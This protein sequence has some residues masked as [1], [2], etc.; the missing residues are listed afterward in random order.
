MRSRIYLLILVLWMTLTGNFASAQIFEWAKAFGHGTFVEVNDLAMD[1]LGDFYIVGSFKGTVDF[2]PGPG[3]LNL[4]SAGFE[5]A[6][7]TKYSSTGAFQWVKTWGSVY[8]DVAHAVEF[9]NGQLYIGGRFQD[10]V[11]FDPGPGSVMR[12]STGSGQSG[13]MLRLDPNGG[14]VDISC[15]YSAYACIVYDMTQDSVGN[16]YMCGTYSD[17][18]NFLGTN[19]T[20]DVLVDVFVAKAD[21]AMNLQW[22]RTFGRFIGQES[23]KSIEL[24]AA[25]SVYVSGSFSG[26][27]DMNPGPGVDNHVGTTNGDG[28]LS[29]FDGQG[30]WKWCK[31]FAGSAAENAMNIATDRNRSIYVGGFFSGN[32]DLDPGPGTDIRVATA[33]SMFIARLDTSGSYVWGVSLPTGSGTSLCHLRVDAHSNIWAGSDFYGTV[34]FDPSPVGNTSLTAISN[35]AFIHRLDSNGQFLGVIRIGNGGAEKARKIQLTGLNSL[36]FTGDF[37]QTVDFDPWGGVYNMTAAGTEAAY[38]EKLR[39][40]SHTTASISLTSCTAIQ[41]PSGNYS[42]TTSGTYQDTIPNST[43]CDS[44]IEVVVTIHP[45]AGDTITLASC[46]P[47]TSPSGNQTWSASG[48]YLDTLTT[49][50]G[51]DSIITAEI[52]ILTAT[53]STLHDTACLSYLSPAGNIYSNSGT[54]TEVIP[55]AAGCDSTITLHLW[56]WNVQASINQSGI[57]LTASPSGAQYQWISCENGGF[58]IPGATAQTYVPTG[59]GTFAAIVTQGGCSDT[60]S[61]VTVVVVG[62]DLGEAAGWSIHP[63][64]AHNQL[65]LEQ[66]GFVEPQQYAIVDALGKRV[67]SG[68]VEGPRTTIEVASLLPGVYFLQVGNGLFAKFMKQ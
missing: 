66:A 56:V 60:T 35:D 25:G 49:V 32:I 6:F 38:I 36:V 26:T 48:T 64:P 15:M 20:G 11:D 10:V 52:T 7:V 22:A 68:R 12:T 55:N 14:F 34:D 59:N 45:P 24:D 44:L 39:F 67:A 46:Q 5:D 65:V 4:T 8:I 2:D 27:V 54:Y 31:Q 21:P 47:I 41:S 28:Y 63:N 30:N 18:T 17:S 57:T 13:F 43:G 29:K 23:C 16:I 51:C 53:Q 37:Q 1:S 40:C 9:S 61:C 42:W 3:V 50:F 19:L 58:V 62:T 33:Y